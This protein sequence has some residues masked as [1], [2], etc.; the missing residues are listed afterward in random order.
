MAINWSATVTA[1]NALSLTGAFDTIR[2]G[3]V[4]EVTKLGNEYD[5]A[6]TADGDA[7]TAHNT[8]VTAWGNDLSATQTAADKAVRYSEQLL[9]SAGVSGSWAP[10]TPSTDASQVIARGDAIGRD[11]R[12]IPQSIDSWRSALVGHLRELLTSRPSASVVSTVST[13]E[14][15]LNAAIQKANDFIAMASFA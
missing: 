6:V 12:E 1:L 2:D 11:R 4:G 9:V 8:A 15:K 14:S 7:Q 13:H 10:S 3:L 5:A